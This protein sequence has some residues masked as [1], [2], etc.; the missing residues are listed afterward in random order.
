M[1]WTLR[2][3]SKISECCLHS[4]QHI[5]PLTTEE[6]CRI[7]AKCIAAANT[8]DSATPTPYPTG[9]YLPKNIIGFFGLFFCY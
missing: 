7:F 4:P 2:R 8:S 3:E 5:P 9:W 1:R 6:R